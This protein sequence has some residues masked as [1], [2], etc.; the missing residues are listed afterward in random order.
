MESWW[1]SCRQDRET[2]YLEP[3][4]YPEGVFL[5]TLPPITIKII[6]LKSFFD[7]L[8]SHF[9]SCSCLPKAEGINPK[10]LCS[11]SEASPWASVCLSGPTSD[12]ARVKNWPQVHLSGWLYFPPAGLQ[13][14]YL[15]CLLILPPLIPVPTSSS[16]GRAPCLP[17]TRNYPN[18]LFTESFSKYLLSS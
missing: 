4:F 9:K 5:A 14:L 7:P 6:F 2:F 15:P 17:C 8:T 11:H 1:H 16:I 12:G 3:S 13:D 10:P 18:W